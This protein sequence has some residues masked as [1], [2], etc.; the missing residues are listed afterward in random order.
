MARGVP[1]R[2]DRPVV[3]GRIAAAAR[4]DDQAKRELLT[5][6]L[7][8]VRNLVRY[9]IHGDA[10]TDD[11]TQEALIEV[12]ADLRDFRG[13]G[14]FEAWVDRVVTSSVLTHI[15][16]HKARSA[17]VIKYRAEL[18]VVSS[19][20]RDDELLYRRQVVR[21]LDE[22]PLEQRHV[23]VLHYVLEMTVPELALALGVPVET[24][25]SRLRLAKGRLRNNLGP[26]FL[27]AENEP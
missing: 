14:R 22:L 24:V 10:N 15:R 21:M 18:E 5:R 25:R 4:G 26:S 19:Q 3:G 16:K 20:S 23:L 1:V 13:E 2:V 11:V 6:L 9:L 8:R 17:Q 12:L 7:P 27:A